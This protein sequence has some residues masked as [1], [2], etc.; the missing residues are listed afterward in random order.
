MTISNVSLNT[1]GGSPVRINALND[2][3]KLYITNLT[4]DIDAAATHP[5]LPIYAALGLPITGQVPQV[6][7]IVYGGAQP[8]AVGGVGG[9]VCADIGANA[10]T[11]RSCGT[12]IAEAFT[13]TGVDGL[14]LTVI[15]G[16]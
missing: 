4:C 9:T 12:G 6:I 14:S 1:S 2:G 11:F 3:G 7:G 15:C 8:I 13:P 16:Y 10:L 5:L